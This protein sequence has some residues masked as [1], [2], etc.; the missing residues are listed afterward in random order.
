MTKKN[1]VIGLD[2]GTDSVRTVIIDAGNG[3]EA[4]SSVFDYPR[5]KMGKYCH[6]GK[7]Q[8]RQHPLDY[9]QGLEVTVEECL[10]KVSEEVR[11][12][13]RGISVDTTGS[14]PVAVNKEGTPLSLIYGFEDNP[15]AMFILWKDHT[16]V[17]EAAEI[18]EKARSWGGIDYTKFEGGVYSSEWFW[19]KILHVLREDSEVAEEAFSWVEHCDWM[20]AI[21]TGNT[22]PLTLKRSRCAAGHKA[23]WHEDFGGLP[24]E[25][26]L[27]A[28]DPVL[29]GLRD[30]LYKETYTSDIPVGK[31]TKEWAKKLGLPD[32]VIV[33]V[34]AFDAHMGAVGG[35]IEPYHLS[36]IVG[37]STCDMLVAP[38]DEMGDKL[39]RGIC[40]QVDGSIT[41]GML[42]LEAGQSAFGDIYA[43]FKDVISWPL[44]EL[45]ANSELIDKDLR[46]KIVEDLT[47]SIVPELTKAAEKVPVGES[48]IVA[49]D[50]MN[51]R[52]TP[53]ANQELKGAI[54]GL[55]LGSD[56]PK[57]FRALVEATAFGSKK[58][59]E[60]FESEGVRID[61]VIALGGVAKKSPFVMQVLADVLNRPIKVARSEQ[62]VALGAAMFAAIVAGIYNSV[63]EA[64]K[65]MGS[66]FDTVYQPDPEKVKKYQELYDKY[67]R[68]GDFIENETQS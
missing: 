19:A 37:T 55:N 9:L 3:E 4:A 24:D 14:T 28:L 58:I 18:N 16:A 40:G 21:L 25:Q 51:G 20:P 29:A 17:Q 26:F 61:G 38:M 10:S 52:R 33:G 65:A 7:N 68:L 54:T 13:I 64:Q 60:R 44:T 46:K 57:I 66:G 11:A 27:V 12:N 47:E 23:M 22:D 67:S 2:Y 41:P 59:V 15:N 42:G 63:E 5:W 43:W 6:P 62:T 45:L 35:E 34:G 8:F 31:I 56:A 36:K 32:D 48:G 30:R 53:D 50:W 49:L 39:V 1:Y